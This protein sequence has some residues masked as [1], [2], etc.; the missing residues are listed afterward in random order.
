MAI[1]YV[2][3][4]AGG[5]ATGADWTNAYLTLAAA[6]AA[7]SAG[8]LIYV[9]SD[10]A[11]A[12]IAAIVL[13][14]AASSL[15]NPVIVLSINRSNDTYLAG[16]LVSI[17]SGTNAS[18]TISNNAADGAFVFRGITFRTASTGNNTANDIA[19]GNASNT[20][21]TLT[22]IDCAFSIK[23]TSTGAQMFLG[24]S[25]AAGADGVVI[26]LV[27]CSFELTNA[28][29]SNGFMQ[30]G[31]ADIEIVNPTITFAG[32]TKPTALFGL[33]AAGLTAAR[34]VIR[35]GD[36]SGFDTSSGF[37]FNVT[38][39]SKAIVELSNLTVSATPALLTGSYLSDALSFTLR[40]VD[41]GD[42]KNVFEYRNRLGSLTENSSIYATSGFTFNGSGIGWQVITTSVCNEANP[43]VCPPLYRWNTGTASQTAA[44]EIARDGTATGYTDRQVWLDLAYAGNGTRPA[45]SIVS[46]RN[47]SPFIGTAVAQG[48]SSNG[49]TGLSGTNAQQKCAVSFTAAD[50]GLI[51][52]RVCFGVASGT[53]S[54]DPLI[55]LS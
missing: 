9:A 13:N 54:I 39:I 45:Y 34:I 55:R 52:G 51:E 37:L 28:N 12:A 21:K 23:A 50:P 49:W 24:N 26:K 19:I 33:V 29:V 11:E 4:G 8:D 22:F 25:A 27:N 5:A 38:N 31:L 20:N 36:L 7:V 46:D 41:S 3:S 53:L 43:F 10:H 14:T 17:G 32:A 2:Y 30:L 6:T 47:T 35:D 16:A 1:K 18:I 42:T 15:D 44:V 40:N 48:T